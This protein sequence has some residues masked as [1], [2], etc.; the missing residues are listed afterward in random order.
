MKKKNF[1]K[2][3]ALLAAMVMAAAVTVTMAGCGGGGEPA[4][5]QGSTDTQITENLGTSASVQVVQVDTKG[6]VP[7]EHLVVETEYGEVNL[8]GIDL[9][10]PMIALTFD[11]GP[12][13]GT[14]KIL[15]VLQE[16]G[17]K[18]TFFELGSNVENYP[19]MT[20]KLADAGMQVASH[21]YSHPDLAELSA[22]DIKDQHSKTESAVKAAAGT[23][24]TAMRVPYGSV[25]DTV[26]SNTQYPI[27]LWSIDTLDW[28]SRDAAAICNSVYNV[29]VEDGDILLF[30][31][32]YDSTAD[33]I[34]IL[35][36]YLKNQGFQLVTVDQMFA[37]K[38]V[39][40]AKGGVY[41]DACGY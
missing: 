9:E 21:T 32:I 16:H 38:E 41:S 15:R 3:G 31:D 20:K 6:V 14:E 17:A 35:V 12:G 28:S 24:I 4:P 22:E 36:P 29:T 27:I 7:K 8:T 26:K 18:A 23:N 2:I 34:E 1:K 19:E 37:A 33:A 39:K 30:H 11:D 5:E 25:D 10:K 13:K 40:L